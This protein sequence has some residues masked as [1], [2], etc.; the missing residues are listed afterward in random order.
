MQNFL[1]LLKQCYANSLN[2][3]LKQK[4]HEECKNKSFFEKV[5]YF[6]W[7][8]IDL[9]S[10]FCSEV[11]KFTSKCLEFFKC[12]SSKIFDYLKDLFLSMK[13]FVED[14]FDLIYSSCKNAF[15][16]TKNFIFGE[17]VEVKEEEVSKAA[18]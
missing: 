11:L 10:Y 6:F 9:I 1:L 3:N 7:Q 8:I 12:Q 15:V 18:S 5:K 17:L 4:N 16:S 2:Q 14:V 13:S